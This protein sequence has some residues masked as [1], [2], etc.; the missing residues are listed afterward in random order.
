MTCIKLK[1]FVPVVKLIE[2]GRRVIKEAWC[3]AS[4]VPALVELPENLIILE[5]SMSDNVRLAVPRVEEGLAMCMLHH[6]TRV[7][8]HLLFG[9]VMLFVFPESGSLV[10]R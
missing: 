7:L 9:H 1:I 2:R 10:N 3:T 5:I 4:S 6:P 8:S